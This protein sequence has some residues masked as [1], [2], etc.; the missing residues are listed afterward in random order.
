MHIQLF[1]LAIIIAILADLVFIPVMSIWIDA[2]SGISWLDPQAVQ[3][4]KHILTVGIF[5]LLIFL[6]GGFI[7]LVARMLKKEEFEYLR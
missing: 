6:V 3:F 1:I 2:I 5:T 7:W 4:N